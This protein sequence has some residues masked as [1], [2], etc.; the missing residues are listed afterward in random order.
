M[1]LKKDYIS[2]F[3]RKV[4]F[5]KPLKLLCAFT[6]VF[7]VKTTSES[8]TSPWC[9]SINLHIAITFVTQEAVPVIQLW[10]FIWNS[11]T[12]YVI[13]AFM[14][15]C[16]CHCWNASPC[17][18]LPVGVETNQAQ[19]GQDYPRWFTRSVMVWEVGVFVL[20]NAKDICSHDGCTEKQF[21]FYSNG[22]F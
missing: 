3:V 18:V 21:I 19:V 2:P 8:F 15:F 10:S 1:G 7:T 17:F 12:G 22:H 11:T 4:S 9:G 16:I 20:V 6:A 13:W 14:W 5:P